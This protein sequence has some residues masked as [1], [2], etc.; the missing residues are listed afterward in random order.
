MGPCAVL[1]HPN[2]S[3]G[4]ASRPWG[5][6]RSSNLLFIDQPTQASFSYDVRVNVSVDLRKTSPFSLRDRMEPQKVPDGIPAWLITNGIFASGRKENTQHSAAIAARACWHF[7]QGFL[8]AFP[9]YNPGTRPNS[10]KVE[11]AAVNLFAESYG[12]IY[13]PT[14]ADFF[15]DQNDRYRNGSLTMNMLEIRLGSIGIINGILDGIVQTVSVANFTHNNT[16]RVEAID[17]FAFE[18]A[19]SSINAKDSCRDLVIQCRNKMIATDP[20]GLGSD[21]STNAICMTALEAC[22]GVSGTI[23]NKI[24]KSVYDIRVRPESSPGAA[25]QEYR[26]TANVLNSIGAPVNFTQG[27]L[28]VSVA[29]ARSQSIPCF[30]RRSYSCADMSSSWRF[31]AWNPTQFACGTTRARYPCGVSLRRCVCFSL[32]IYRRFLEPSASVSGLPRY[33]LTLTQ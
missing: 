11:A 23:Y 13:G 30:P 20:E 26:N 2:G 31:S 10:T 24:G 18:S 4:T 16:Y 8:S 9:Q 22:N 33:T 32:T 17:L 21:A 6:D 19:I 14:F 15:E 1:Q 28:A 27:S 29:F 25:Y 5:W 3:Y 12:G 7:L